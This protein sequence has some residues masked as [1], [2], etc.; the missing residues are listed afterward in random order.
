MILETAEVVCD[1]ESNFYIDAKEDSYLYL[2]EANDK[3]NRMWGYYFKF[4]L[5]TASNTAILATLSAISCYST[6]G[7]LDEKFLY[8]PYKVV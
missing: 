4:M 6:Y 1:S 8:H 2:L 3:S 5:A 7:K